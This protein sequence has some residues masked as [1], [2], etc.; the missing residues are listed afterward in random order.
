MSKSRIFSFYDL[1]FV[2][3]GSNSIYTQIVCT[4]VPLEIHLLDQFALITLIK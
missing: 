1:K 3:I 2:Y 4:K